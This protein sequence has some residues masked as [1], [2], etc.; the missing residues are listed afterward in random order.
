MS[1]DGKT[2]YPSFRLLKAA[3]GAWRWIYYKTGGQPLAISAE[4]FRK[5]I[6]CVKAVRDMKGAEGAP[7]YCDFPEEPPA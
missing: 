3:D 7:I 2:V 5:Y 6:E 1:S 4:S